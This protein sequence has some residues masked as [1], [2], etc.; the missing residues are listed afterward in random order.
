MVLSLLKDT[1]VFKCKFHV[2]KISVT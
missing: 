2:T 1:C